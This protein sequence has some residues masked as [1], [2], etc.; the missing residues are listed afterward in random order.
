MAIS[1]MEFI[2]HL[3]CM[4]VGASLGIG[5]SFIVNCSL[6]EISKSKLFS[7]VN[8][9]EFLF[10]IYKMLKNSKII[11]FCMRIYDNWNIHIN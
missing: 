6:I 4:L 3:I 8:N 2:I 10:L 7:I 5:I 9:F 11:V 1:S